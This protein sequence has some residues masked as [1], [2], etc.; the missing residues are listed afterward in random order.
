MCH[1]DYTNWGYQE[2]LEQDLATPSQVEPGMWI[3]IFVL[4]WAWDKDRYGEFADMVTLEWLVAKDSEKE[5]SSKIVLEFG[6]S[7]A[8]EEQSQGEIC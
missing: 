3:D 5:G 4:A 2:P 7:T 6:N 1:S 8:V